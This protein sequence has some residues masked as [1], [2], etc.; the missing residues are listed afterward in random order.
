M[1]ICLLH[2]HGVC[3]IDVGLHAFVSPL[4]V[5]H[6][7]HQCMCDTHTCVYTNRINSD[8]RYRYIVSYHGVI[9]QRMRD[10]YTYC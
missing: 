5:V 6:Q 10:R 7:S 8:V 4:C 1:S 2:V 3:A 9:Y